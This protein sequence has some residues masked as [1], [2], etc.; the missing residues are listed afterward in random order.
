M[1]DT[2]DE[3]LR[4]AGQAILFT[5]IILSVAFS[6]FAFSDFSPN[7]NFGIVTSSAL[8]LAFVVDLLLLPALLSI[9]DKKKE[10]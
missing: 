8:V 2:F 4:Y 7:Q 6:M 5:T 9:A 3:V 10:N 1:E